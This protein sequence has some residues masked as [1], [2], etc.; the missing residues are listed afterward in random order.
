MC[1]LHAIIFSS[2]KDI[3]SLHCIH[4]LHTHLDT[5]TSSAEHKLSVVW[6]YNHVSAHGTLALTG[7]QVSEAQKSEYTVCLHIERHCSQVALG[8]PFHFSSQITDF[9][10]FYPILIHNIVIHKNL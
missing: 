8:R 2:F 7:L 6:K 5:N 3:L 10:T 9:L 1:M 4:Y